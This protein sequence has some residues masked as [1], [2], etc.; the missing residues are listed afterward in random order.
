VLQ[1]RLKENATRVLFRSQAIDELRREF[2]KLVDDEHSLCLVAER[3]GIFCN[4]FA[5]FERSELEKRFPDLARDPTAS[6]SELHERANAV[7]L[8][9]QDL[10]A[11]RLPCDVK[12]ACCAGWS[13]LTDSQLAQLHRETFGEDVEVVPSP[14]PPAR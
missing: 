14:A 12:S 8:S 11:G 4:G 5:R 9:L 2:L 10:K 1:S 3:R 7:Q 13:E 6:E